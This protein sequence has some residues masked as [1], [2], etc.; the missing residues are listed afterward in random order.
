MDLI[1][2]W[3]REGEEWFKVLERELFRSYSR[4]IRDNR[5]WK[6]GAWWIKEFIVSFDRGF[7]KEIKKVIEKVWKE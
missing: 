7:T 6:R 5:Y 4:V 3:I 1:K 2:R